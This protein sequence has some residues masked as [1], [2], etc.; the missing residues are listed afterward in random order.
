VAVIQQ[1]LAALGFIV[2]V[3][4]IF[5]PEEATR[6]ASGRSYVSSASKGNRH[7]REHMF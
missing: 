4:G 5:G 3:D 7:T 6:R 1:A 2:S